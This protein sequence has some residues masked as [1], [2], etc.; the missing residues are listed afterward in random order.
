MNE[1]NLAR[2]IEELAAP[3]A[4]SLGLGIW[5]VAAA[6]GKRSIVRIYVDDENG[7]DIDRC[8][9]LSRLL[10]LT[11]DVEDL[12]PGAYLLEVSSP[13]LE[14][15]FFRPEQL[16]GA[17]GKTV[18]VSLHEAGETYPG[19]RKLLGTLTGARDGDFTLLPLDGAGS[20]PAGGPGDAPKEAVFAW[21]AIKKAKLVHFL[22]EQPGT[23]KGKK[24][25][26]PN[27][28]RKTLAEPAAD[29]GDAS[30]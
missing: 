7:V 23:A 22:P 12:I 8:A 11:L 30:A 24:G 4:A 25:A 3:L 6:P 16:A 1:T 21:E 20:V 10:G 13:G 26:R 19:R 15:T 27:R 29:P 9:E 17:V 14:R 28:T 18:E 2:T 5:G